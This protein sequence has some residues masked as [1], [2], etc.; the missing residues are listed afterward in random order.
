[1]EIRCKNCGSVYLTENDG[2][3]TCRYCGS[4]VVSESKDEQKSKACHVNYADTDLDIEENQPINE[5]PKCE[6]V[7]TV[8]QAEQSEAYL[9]KKGTRRFLGIT[10]VLVI[11]GLIFT[12][13]MIVTGLLNTAAHS[14]YSYRDENRVVDVDD[15]FTQ[16]KEKQQQE[17]EQWQ[18]E[19]GITDSNK[20]WNN[21]MGDVEIVNSDGNM[22]S[23]IGGVRAT[24]I[25]LGGRDFS[26]YNC[27]VKNISGRNLTDLE[28]RL[29]FKSNY[30]FSATIVQEFG[31]GD[32]QSLMF[33]GQKASSSD[34]VKITC[35]VDNHTYDL[36]DWISV[37]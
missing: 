27:S 9:P 3:W 24:G 22:F 28:F 17:I 29:L 6:E 10:S 31:A 16:E 4:K 12:G 34:L 7:E 1:M 5:E 26:Q 15:W 30:S 14:D 37:R 23:V 8:T 13:I 19:H 18:S 36:T 20:N 33:F 35:T 21:S 2:V 11:F 32:T 25:S